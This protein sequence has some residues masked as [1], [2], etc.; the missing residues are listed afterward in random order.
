MTPHE[1]TYDVGCVLIFVLETWC[2]RHREVT[3]GE[4]WS[5]LKLRQ[6]HAF[7][8]CIQ[9]HKEGR[10]DVTKEQ[11]HHSPGPRSR[12]LAFWEFNYHLGKL[13]QEGASVQTLHIIPLCGFSRQG[14]RAP[15]SFFFK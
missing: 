1:K 5:W 13:V 3:A 6:V 14:D 11:D 15:G 12:G 7:H 2:L 9:K 4:G 10:A 8:L